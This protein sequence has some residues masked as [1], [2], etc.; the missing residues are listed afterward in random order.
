M[1]GSRMTKTGIEKEMTLMLTL[2]HTPNSNMGEECF[3]Y[4]F[5]ITSLLY[6]PMPM[7]LLFENTC[8]SHAAKGTESLQFNLSHCA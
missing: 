8:S 6:T 7:M 2:E 3:Y 1:D 5:F 4:H